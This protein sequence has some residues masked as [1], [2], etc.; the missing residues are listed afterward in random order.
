MTYI[1]RSWLQIHAQTQL[2]LH[3]QEQPAGRSSGQP[4]VPPT[5]QR[6]KE[7][8]LGLSPASASTSLLCTILLLSPL[9]L[10]R[11]PTLSTGPHTCALRSSPLVGQAVLLSTIAKFHTVTSPFRLTFSLPLSLFLS[12]GAHLQKCSQHST[13]LTCQLLK[14]IRALTYYLSLFE[15]PWPCISVK[16]GPPVTYTWVRSFINESPFICLHKYAPSAGH[17]EINRV[18]PLLLRPLRKRKTH[19]LMG[20]NHKRLEEQRAGGRGQ[21]C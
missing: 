7:V 3:P 17:T 1:S 9:G 13:W 11:I 12:P 2:I 18:Q 15:V 10:S 6:G 4:D 8:C 21:L 19:T 5:H 14:S 20:K 16:V